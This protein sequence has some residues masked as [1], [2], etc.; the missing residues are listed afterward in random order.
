MDIEWA[1][2]GH[3]GKLFIVQARPETV[4]SRGQVMERYTLHSQ[5]KIIAEGR[6][7]G[8]RIGAGPVKVIHDIS[9][10]NRI[11][12]GDVLVTD[13][14]DPDWEPI[15]KKASA[16]VT[17]R[18]GR[19]CHAAINCIAPPKSIWNIITTPYPHCIMK[20]K[21]TKIKSI[22]KQNHMA[23]KCFCIYCFLFYIIMWRNSSFIPRVNIIVSYSFIFLKNNNVFNMWLFL[24]SK[25]N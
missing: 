9:E 2:D 24:Y 12:P 17:N 7:I 14:T 19:T 18:G 3:T 20:D 11:E 5:G 4:R 21:A 1:K 22:N 8:H 13:M 10:M 23:F 25:I 16:I 15:M 6:A